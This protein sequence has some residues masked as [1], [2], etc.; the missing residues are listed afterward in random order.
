MLSALDLL[1]HYLVAFFV[2]GI[3]NSVTTSQAGPTIWLQCPDK[4]G[5]GF[6]RFGMN[7]QS[8][9]VAKMT[10]AIEHDTKSASLLQELPRCIQN[11]LSRRSRLVEDVCGSEHVSVLGA[12]P[13]VQKCKERTLELKRLRRSC[14]R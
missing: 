10:R 13:T 8:K 4:E 9:K 14:S 11:Q 3:E 2:T 12:R 5:L 1:L 6:V 7:E